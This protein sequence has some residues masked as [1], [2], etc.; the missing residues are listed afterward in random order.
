M[1][2]FKLFWNR[3]LALRLRYPASVR[4]LAAVLLVAVLAIPLADGI[5]FNGH[6]VAGDPALAAVGSYLRNPLSLFAQRSPGGRGAG[7]LIQSKHRSNQ[8]AG[9]RAKP[10]QE[11]V[12]SNVR[13][14]P[15]I[16][17]FVNDVV[18]IGPGPDIAPFVPGPVVPGPAVPQIFPPPVVPVV[19]P[20]GST[21]SGPSGPTGPSG[22][23]GTTAV[24]ETSTWFM[25]IWG[26]GLIGF[27]LRTRNRHHA[28]G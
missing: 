27:A 16:P 17:N 13:Y 8:L 24:P 19:T 12:L 9:N 4:S 28:R 15:S 14:A 25:L 1:D 10:P 6:R 5:K 22:P 23:G 11:R 2:R 3:A 7:R 18:P 26:M 21:P 20:P